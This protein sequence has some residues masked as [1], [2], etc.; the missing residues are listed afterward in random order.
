MT[1]EP[2]S[3]SAIDDRIARD[4]EILLE[5]LKKTPVVQMA[6]EKTQI[7]RTTYYR[8]RREDTTFSEAADE[9]LAEG[10]LLVNDVA[11]SQLLVAIKEGNF[12]AV[13]YWLRHHHPS[14]ANKIELNASMKIDEHLSPEQ[15]AA[16]RAALRLAGI[17][18]ER[19]SPPSS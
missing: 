7:G 6:C 4:K 16:V 18:T 2:V 9:A 8:W 11:E 19:I 14:Y 3:P 12:P 15:E 10:K 1:H 5:Q 13:T 17:T